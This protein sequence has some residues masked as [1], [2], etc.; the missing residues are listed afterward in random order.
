MR[1]A[2]L[3]CGYV[4]LELA[5]QL[6]SDGHDVWGVRRSDAGLDAVSDTGA[7]AVRADVTDAESLAAVPDVDHLVFAASS[8]GRGADAA[9]TIYVDGLR[10]AIDH[11]AGRRS[12]PERLVYTSST[13]VYGN[14]DGA[15]VDESTPLDP[16]TDKTRVLAEAERIAREY[17]GAQGIEGT[18]ARF[19][20]LYG[21]D[22]YR[23][24]R[25]LNGPV[26]EGYLN[27][28]HR[29]DAAGAIKY[30]LETDRARD[31]TVLVV[32]D[33]PVSKH[34]F[35]DWL[36]DECGVPRPEKRTNEERLAAD[37]LSEVVRRRILTSK[38]CSNEYLC[39][40]GY[41]FS[42]P[43]YRAGYRAAIDAYRATHS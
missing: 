32:D 37:D 9:R 38:R 28:V 20:G 17:A 43:T 22:R 13:G 27:M 30:L 40:L 42:Y 23:L 21:P 36:A 10:T 35:A 5:R 8:G 1:V 26:T 2:I 4:G 16:T 41:E 33:E 15:F 31:E 39:T 19:A 25:Y 3:G 12:S 34:E 11:F 14:H 6:V 7:E 24:E 29:D 18:V